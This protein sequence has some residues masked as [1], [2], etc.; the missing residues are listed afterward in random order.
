MK[1]KNFWIILICLFGFAIT[2]IA[3]E[4]KSEETIGGD[5]FGKGGGYIHPSLTVGG[6]Y[7]DNIFNTEKDTRDDFI[8]VISPE[9]WLALPG[10]RIREMELPV[11]P[12]TPAGFTLSRPNPE[13]FRRYQTYLSYGGDFYRYTEYTEEDKQ[14]HRFDGLFQYNFRGGLSVELLGQYLDTFDPVGVA[15]VTRHDEYTEGLFNAIL[16]YDIT[17]KFKLRLDYTHID[18]NYDDRPLG[19]IPLIGRDRRDNSYSGY[20]FFKIRPKTSIFA[21]YRFI[22]I[23]YDINVLADDSRE[24]HYFGG[25]QWRLTPKSQGSLKLGY[26][27]KDFYDNEE[28]DDGDNFIFEGEIRHLF[29]PKTS[30]SLVGFGRTDETTIYDTNYVLTYG[31][32]AQYNQRITEKLSGHLFF[33]YAWDQYQGEITFDGQTKQRE[34]DL[35]RIR[36]SLRYEFT[37]WL[38]ADA[39]YMYTHR[40]SNFSIFDF[41]ENRFSLRISL[42]LY[43]RSSEISDD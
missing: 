40:D 7:S 32:S 24:H 19:E 41:A 15:P 42:F 10:T 1:N 16:S 23:D 25:V 26:G 3:D 36:P 28:A 31:M 37:H 8:W 18:L 29:T 43:N 39:A 30:L 6:I 27:V 22:D 21:Q 34:D 4:T 17:E 12:K 13:V 35:I 5:I 2:A 14:S 20:L 38:M 11:S 33:S 9:I